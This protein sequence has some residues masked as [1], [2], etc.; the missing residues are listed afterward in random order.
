MNLGQNIKIRRLEL[1]MSQ[2]ELAAAAGYKTPS[3]IAKIEAGDNDIPISKLE[4]LAAALDTTV[5]RLIV[6]G[7]AMSHSVV[8]GEYAGAQ[9][10]YRCAAVILA[11]GKSS[12]NRQNT[13]NQ[14]INVL[15]KP[16]I[17]YS[18]EAY[19]AHPLIDDIVVVCLKG[20]EE[21]VK[22]YANQ[23]GISKLK[24]IVPA[25]ESGLSSIKAGL[26][27]VQQLAY[28]H[29]DVVIVQETTRPFITEETISKLLN[30]CLERGSSVICEPFSDHLVFMRNDDNS[31]SYVDRNRIVSMQSPDAHRVGTLVS[32]F[33]DAEARGIPITENCCGLLLHQLGYPLY[34]CE[35]THNNIKLVRQEDIAVFTTLLRLRDL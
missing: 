13:P 35:G 9:K 27:K 3:A 30:A 28:E 11:G 31:A 23:Y 17:M 22:G 2:K 12:R 19:Q 20:W 21:I 1:N 6:G 32:M 26:E 29:D 7:L 24:G 4:T 18:M 16:V 15:G 5:E 10:D 14:F 25:G 33:A 8:D 34:F